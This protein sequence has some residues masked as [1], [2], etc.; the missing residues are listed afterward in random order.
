MTPEDRD[1][2]LTFMREGLYAVQ[3]SVSPN[4]TP[5][6][7][8]VGVIVTDRFEL[9]FDA[10]ASSRKTFNLRRNAAVALVIGPAGPDAA[11]TV[12][13]EGLADE[14]RGADL[15]RLLALYFA[16]FPDGR[17]RQQQ[18]DI[19]YWRVRPTWLRDSDFS[20]IPAAIA[21]FVSSDLEGVGARRGGDAS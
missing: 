10:L 19:T 3:S 16:R 6:S 12:Q 13:L 11:R 4:G 18:P 5:Q 17:E 14:P 21:E 20:A 2:L 8:I 7:A 1:G 9:F 15:D